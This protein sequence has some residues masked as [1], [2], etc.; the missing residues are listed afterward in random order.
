VDN[1]FCSHRCT[2]DVRLWSGARSVLDTPA[3]PACSL[4]SFLSLFTAVLTP[5]VL[6]FVFSNYL[7]VLDSPEA[8]AKRTQGLC[9]RC[10]NLL[11]ANPAVQSIRRNIQHSR[12][13]DRRVSLRHKYS[14]THT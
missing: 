5:I 1:F 8:H 11:F 7:Y 10:W 12:N 4:A 6:G 3:R 14:G 13:F 9:F 2:S